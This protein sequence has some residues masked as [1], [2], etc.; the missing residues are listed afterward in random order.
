MSR[1]WSW[2]NLRYP[3]ACFEEARKNCENVGQDSLFRI[4]I[5]AGN[6]PIQ[7]L[8]SCQY[9]KPFGLAGTS[10]TIQ[11]VEGKTFKQR[12]TESL[13]FS[14]RSVNKSPRPCFTPLPKL[15]HLD[16]FTFDLMPFGCFIFSYLSL[17]SYGNILLICAPFYL[18]PLFQEHN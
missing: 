3:D 7:V 8:F 2:H 11:Q 9:E 5:R 17:C 4:G 6:L 1:K 12:L 10:C 16:P 14:R 18:R 13:T 15:H